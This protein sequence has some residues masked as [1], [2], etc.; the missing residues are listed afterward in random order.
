MEGWDLPMSFGKKAKGP[1][2][3]LQAKV[4]STKRA[5]PVAAL[6]PSKAESPGPGPPA[7]PV[8]ADDDDEEIGPA[9]PAAKRKAGEE[10]DDDDDD[11]GV[12]EDEAEVDRTPVTHEIVL[13]DHKKAVSAIAVEPSGARIASG[14]HDYDCKLWDFG[15]MDSRLRP[16]KS[17]EPNGNY[18]VHDL[19]YSPDGKHLLVISG[20]TYPKVFNRDGEEAME[21][22][23]GDVYLRDM[24]HTKGHTAEINAGVW[25]PT[26]DSLF[27]TCANDSTLRIWNVK[28]K[29][30]QKQVIVVKSKERGA[31]TNVTACAYSPDGTLIAGGCRDGA[32]H[33]WKT[34]SNMA[35]PDRTG[36]TAFV[37]GTA[38]TS[39]VFSPDSKRLVSRGGDGDDT[40]KLW[41]PKSL[42]QPLAVAKGFDTVYPETAVIYSPD[43]QY[44]LAG[45]TVNSRDPDAVGEIV[46]LSPADLSVLRRVPIAKGASVVRL[47]WHSRINQIF[48]TLSNGFIYVLYSP[49]SSIHGALLPLAKMPRSAPRDMSFSSADL[50]PVIFTPDALPMFADKRHGLS[51]HQQEKRAKKFKPQ[52][53]V[54]GH[55]KGGR[56][57][58]AATV[59]MVQSLFPNRADANEDPREA[60]LRYATEEEQKRKKQ[61]M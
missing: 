15:G 2:N 28:D 30:K 1:K 32:L 48:C 25:H 35:R 24:N 10:S 54:S 11:D 12:S 43:G 38:P 42:R 55:G 14:S 39:V 5:E 6:P 47:L 17:W 34:A 4:E 51:L 57:G 52:E 49:Q 16:F 61:E 58:A 20:T 18:F 29:S 37:K 59:G 23:K 56:I 3:V 40:L 33:V 9:P 31:R 41:D 26:D 45:T 50:Q 36:E 44:I 27:L 53:P 19:C 7:P 21:F 46:F 8:A 60:L 22:M 13:K